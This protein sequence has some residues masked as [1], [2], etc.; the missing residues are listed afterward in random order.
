[1]SDSIRIRLGTRSSALARWQADW[2][3][4]RL[5]REGVQVEM[6]LI[7]TQGDAR[8]GPIGALGGQGVFTKEIQRAAA[9]QS[10]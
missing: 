10:H 3:A 2:V 9:R 1:M 6:V 8:S 4:E 5:T 7:T